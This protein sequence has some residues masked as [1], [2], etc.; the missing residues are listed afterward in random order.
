VIPK[1]VTPARITQNS[2]VF[3]F[4]L[5]ADDV[6]AIEALGARNFRTC[7]PR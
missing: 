3:D 7:N 2:E 5:S 4:E 1:S 6:K